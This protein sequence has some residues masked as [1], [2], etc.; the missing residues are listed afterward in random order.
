MHAGGFEHLFD[1]KEIANKKIYVVD[2]HHKVLAPWALVRRQLELPP[3]LITLDHHTDTY[4]AFLG[5]AALSA[6]FQHEK[7]ETIRA[8]FVAKLD[9][10]NDAQ[11]LASIENLRHDEH[12]DAAAQCGVIGAAFC[13]QLSDSGGSPESI[14][15]R[16]F[17]EHMETQWPN[18]PT[19]QI[20]SRPFTYEAPLN[21]V[22]TVPHECYIGCQQRP[23]NDDCS[24]QHASQVLE[25]VYLEDQLRRAAEMSRSIGLE[26]LERY[27][28]ILDI[29]LDVFHTMQA[30]EPVTPETFHRLAR[31]AAAITIATEAECVRD[32]WKDEQNELSSD[33]LLA[34]ILQ[35]LRD[36]LE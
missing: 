19:L 5:A 12:I 2:D 23:H 30:I 25:S 15:K 16:K 18:P 11:L 31:G 6:P 34:R 36:A 20:P 27:P 4:E 24:I 8:E 13:I 14:E 22:F 26:H 1:L 17:R 10:Q 29:D 35:H 33:D 7:W 21:C 3:N 28:Y 9:W 32:L